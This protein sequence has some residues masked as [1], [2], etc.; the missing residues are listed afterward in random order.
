[1][2]KSEKKPKRALGASQTIFVSLH[3]IL[4]AG[5]EMYIAG[6]ATYIAGRAT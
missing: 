4:I 5:R 2:E 1:M 6:R 3:Q